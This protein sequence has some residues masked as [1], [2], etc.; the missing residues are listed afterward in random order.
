MSDLSVSD[1][2]LLFHSHFLTLFQKLNGL[3]LNQKI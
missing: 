3:K 2:L 1:D